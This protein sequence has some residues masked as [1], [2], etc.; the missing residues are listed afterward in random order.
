MLFREVG[1]KDC[2]SYRNQKFYSYILQYVALK[3]LGITVQTYHQPTIL[4]NKEVILFI[5]IGDVK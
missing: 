3:T 1:Y 5:I 2:K 4:A